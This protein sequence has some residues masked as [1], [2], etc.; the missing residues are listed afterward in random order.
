V[1]SAAPLPALEA[2]L[3]GFTGWIARRHPDLIHRRRCA[4]SVERFLGWRRDQ[5]AQD[6]LRTEEVYYAQL[7]GGGASEVQ[8][9]EARP[10]MGLFCLRLG[11]N[12]NAHVE[13][14]SMGP[15]F[16]TTPLPRGPAG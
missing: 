14:E 2:T 15:I 11:G 4:G 10:A 1:A 9:I 6:A 8:V 3:A 5:R 12:S 16:A 7:P 13:S